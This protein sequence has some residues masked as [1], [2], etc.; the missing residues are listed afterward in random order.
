MAL[1]LLL[2]QH[3]LVEKLRVDRLPF[4]D[5]ALHGGS[6]GFRTL[7]CQLDYI[8]VVY[9]IFVSHTLHDGQETIVGALDGERALQDLHFLGEKC[10]MRVVLVGLIELPEA[11][12]EKVEVCPVIIHKV[13][14][15]DNIRRSRLREVIIALRVEI[16][17]APVHAIVRVIVVGLL[18]A[19]P[20]RMVPI[21]LLAH[22]NVAVLGRRVLICGRV[23]GLSRV[24]LVID[25]VGLARD[26][27]GQDFVGLLDPLEL[28]LGLL[29]GLLGLVMLEVGMVLFGE[30]VIAQLYVFLVAVRPDLKSL[31]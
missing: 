10:L 26:R 29:L 16:L 5:V 2:L 3:S 1:L 19:G 30:L 23:P 12:Q 13:V 14:G 7:G 9:L 28:H 22:M 15:H 8:L 17:A 4:S 11:E 27:I 6:D 31:I 21:S 18:V 24:Q 25:V 20:L